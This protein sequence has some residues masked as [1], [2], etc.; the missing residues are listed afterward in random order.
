MMELIR[1]RELAQKIYD[2]ITQYP[3]THDQGSWQS[4]N[5]CGTTYCVAGW[6]VAFQDSHRAHAER[7]VD[8]WPL[9]RRLQSELGASSNTWEALGQAL[10]GLTE[11]QVTRL[12][13]SDDDRAPVL[14]SEMFDLNQEGNE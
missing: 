8:S 10:L 6:A 14:L 3:A 1:G 9:R 11:E 12:F 13:Y 5:E 4:V 2:Q 7:D